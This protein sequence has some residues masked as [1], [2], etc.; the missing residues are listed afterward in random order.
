MK[1]LLL[2][3][4]LL[5]GCGPAMEAL[6]SHFC[7]GREDICRRIATRTWQEVMGNQ[8]EARLSW[9]ESRS[10]WVVVVADEWASAPWRL[11]GER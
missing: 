7:D 3:A 1:R 5:A 11:V 8:G 9:D 4:V 6:D 10:V 2:G